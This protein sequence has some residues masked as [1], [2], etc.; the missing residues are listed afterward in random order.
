MATICLCL[1]ECG[2]KEVASCK[3]K[4]QNSAPRDRRQLKLK[5]TLSHSDTT[6]R[7]ALERDLPDRARAAAAIASGLSQLDQAR[8]A[9]E[10]QRRRRRELERR[11]RTKP[12]GGGGWP[13]RCS[14]FW[15]AAAVCFFETQPKRLKDNNNKQQQ[16]AAAADGSP[17]GGQLEKERKRERLC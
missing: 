7:G 3:P 8:Q 16:C 15:Q 2:F 1:Q 9:S 13:E 4:P 11:P 17:R 5:Y 10:R 6:R 12:G 14:L